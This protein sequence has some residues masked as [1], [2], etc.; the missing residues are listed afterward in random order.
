MIN[1]E[2]QELK[3][4]WGVNSKE[5][6]S[7]ISRMRENLI[8]RNKGVE[9]YEFNYT[10]KSKSINIANELNVSELFAVDGDMTPQGI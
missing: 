9:L 4:L 3:R 8:N 2:F 6:E 1:K 10:S 7:L 5:R